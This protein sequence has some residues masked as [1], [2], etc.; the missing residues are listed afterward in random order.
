MAIVWVVCAMENA[1]LGVANAMQFAMMVHGSL[2]FR[3]P[4]VSK[5]TFSDGRV[6][7]DKDGNRMPRTD[8]ERV[9]AA[10]ASV[11]EFRDL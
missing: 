3:I 4:F 11:P 10:V 9:E 1:V 6:V 7:T 2:T 8:A 5:D